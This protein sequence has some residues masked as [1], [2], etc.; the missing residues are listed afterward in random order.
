MS[1]KKGFTLS[2][3]LVALGIVGIISAITIPSIHKVLPDKDKGIV[4]KTYKT[5]N[6]INNDILGD[7]GLYMFNAETCPRAILQ[8]VE[9]PVKFNTNNNKYKNLNK[10]TALLI[11]NLTL[12]DTNVSITSGSANFNT[13]DGVSW[14]VKPLSPSGNKPEAYEI[15]IDT[16]NSNRQNCQYSN[17]CKSPRL[18]RFVVDKYGMTSPGDALTEAYLNNPN[19]LSDRS[20]DLKAA[21]RSSTNF[22]TIPE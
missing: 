15:I 18:F 1:K 12:A 6:E 2:E 8:C 9:K 13:A 10:Y 4:L 11:D 19:D 21:A 20:N 16:H 14:S 3:I 17:S 7:P 5:I 22:S